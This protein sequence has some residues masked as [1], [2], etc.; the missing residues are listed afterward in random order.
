M[1]DKTLTKTVRGHFSIKKR[2]TFKLISEGL[3]K[4]PSI[5][6]LINYVNNL[7]WVYFP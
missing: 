6:P 4:V 2:K 5:D 3:K 1:D 7:S